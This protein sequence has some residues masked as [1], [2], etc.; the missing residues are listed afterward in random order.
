MY[1][2]YIEMI[3]HYFRVKVRGLGFCYKIVIVFK[4]IISSQAAIE[5]WLV[6]AQNIPSIIIRF[7]SNTLYHLIYAANH[8]CMSKYSLYSLFGGQLN[9]NNMQLTESLEDQNIESL[10]CSLSS[11][12]SI[13][14]RQ[15]QCLNLSQKWFFTCIVFN[16]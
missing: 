11:R 1:A 8:A 5:N 12:I 9:S 3:N 13:I 15:K 14:S 6:A 4:L 16:K 7:P 10:N 2:N